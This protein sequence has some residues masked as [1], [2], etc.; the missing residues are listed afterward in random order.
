MAYSTGVG[1]TIPHARP[2]PFDDRPEYLMDAPYRVAFDTETDG[3][4][5]F[6]DRRPFL[7]TASD[8]DRDYLFQMPA[9]NAGLRDAL[10]EAGE[11]I[12]HNASFDAHMLV[13]AGVVSL[14]EM[15][16]LTLHDTD[17]L[18]RV[19]FGKDEVESYRLKSL[20]TALVDPKAGDSEKVVKEAM[21]ELKLIRSA[22]QHYLPN[23]VY[24]LVHDAMPEVLETYALKDTRYTYDLFHAL[25][26]VA[27]PDQLVCYEMERTLLPTI[28]RMEHTGIALDRTRA[29]EL[30]A[31]YSERKSILEAALLEHNAG[32]RLNWDS[33]ADTVAL[34][35]KHGVTITEKTPTGQP[36]TDKWTLEKYT[37]IPVVADLLEYRNTTKFLSTYIG[38]MCDRDTVHPSFMQIGAWTGR[39]SC[40]RPNMQNI[41]SR[42]G[43]EMRTMI[44]PREGHYFAV[45]DYS[46]IEL[47]LLAYYMNDENLWA[48]IEEGDPFLWLGERIYGTDDQSKWPVTR[49]NL[50]N[51]FYAMTYGAGGPKL[52]STIGGGMT[53]DEG[54]ALRKSMVAALGPRYTALTRR[55]EQQIKA[56]GYVTTLGRRVQKVPRDRSYIGLNALIQGSASDI[57]KTGLIRAD[58]A[59]RDLGAYPVLTVHDEIVAE[60]PILVADDCLEEMQA[61]MASASDLAKQGKLVLK[62]SGVVCQHHYG[63]AK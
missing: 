50:K 26:A 21:V 16:G 59:L 8:Y 54:R 28:I 55:I 31:V 47:R 9:D 25:L 56:K 18:A 30:R 10:L 17:L 12:F 60:V 32:E 46:S 45:A 48:I 40:M 62:A 63:E 51:G 41:P 15:V 24:K 35:E 23:G 27:T 52:A 22:D 6:D 4:E 34:F 58:Q 13:A 38:P 39:Q 61:A 11:L 43:P 37:H 14:E 49:S 5:W 57:L 7:A 42:S 29:S 44:V 19:V 3:L 2:I 53:D 20:A 36:K 1:E 33:A